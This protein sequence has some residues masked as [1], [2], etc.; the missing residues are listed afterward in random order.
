MKHALTCSV[1]L[2]LCLTCSAQ[3]R[4]GAWAGATYVRQVLIPIEDGPSTNILEKPEAGMGFT[5]GLKTQIPMGGPLMLQM[6]AAYYELGYGRTVKYT[7]LPP[8][9]LLYGERIRTRSAGLAVLPTAH[10]GN[11]R[12]KPELFAGAELAFVFSISDQSNPDVRFRDAHSD[13]TVPGSDSRAD[14]LAPVRLTGMAGAGLAITAGHAAIYLQC[15]YVHGFT[16]VYR[17]EVALTDNIGAPLGTGRVVDRAF[18]VNVGFSVP[19]SS[20]TTPE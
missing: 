7:K 17:T 1:S 19:L 11:G 6:D 20:A 8:G 4:M 3:V 5:A 16:N 12:V 13:L 15:R 9:G 2:L 10:I 14:L 18:A